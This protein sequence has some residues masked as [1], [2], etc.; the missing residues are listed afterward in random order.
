M[1]LASLV[2]TEAFQESERT[3]IA[4]VYLNRLR[5]RMPLQC[6]P[7]VIYA[8]ERAGKYRGTLRTVDLKFPSPYNTYVNAGLPPGPIASPGYASLAAATRP[9]TTKYLFFVRTVDGHQYF[10]ETLL[11]QP[12]CCGLSKADAQYPPMIAFLS[13]GSNLD[14]RERYLREGIKGLQNRGVTSPTKRK[15]VSNPTQGCYHQP[16][17]LNTAVEVNTGIDPELLLDICLQVER[18]NHRVRDGSRGPRTLDIDIIFFGSLVMSTGALVVPHPRFAERRFV[19]EPL[20]EIAG[21]FVDPVR[22]MTVR[23]LARR[24]HRSGG[25]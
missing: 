7:T 1:I 22:G 24:C 20:A 21:D 13:L 12:G 4:S 23:E 9:A 17:F 8:L 14:N 25:G 16:W 19:L 2:E 18:D 10:S 11:P 6:D 15:C 5:I 3:T